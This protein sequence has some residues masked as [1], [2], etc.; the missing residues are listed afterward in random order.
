MDTEAEGKNMFKTETG[1]WIE[2]ML[3]EMPPPPQQASSGDAS[4]APAPP[5]PAGPIIT[6]RGVD[7]TKYD[8]SGNAKMAYTLLSKLHSM[9]GYFDTNGTV[10]RGTLYTDTNSFMTE[11]NLRLKNPL[12]L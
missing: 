6:V 5:P 1:I 8:P 10:F 4:S 11:I 7:M 12:L 2:K 3:T 9:T